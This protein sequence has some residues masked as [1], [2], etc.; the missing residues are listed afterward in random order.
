MSTSKTKKAPVVGNTA[1]P[2]AAKPAGVKQWPKSTNGMSASDYL[3]QAIIYLANHEKKSPLLT[4]SICWL[5]QANCYERNTDL[6]A[7]TDGLGVY[8]NTDWF[9]QMNVEERAFVFTHE[10]MHAIYRHV[11]QVKMLI[12]PDAKSHTWRKSNIAMDVLI[13]KVVGD[14]FVGVTSTKGS[15]GSAPF[16][17]REA[18]VGGV[19]IDTMVQTS[20]GKK[21]PLVDEAS[22]FDPDEHDWYWIFQ[23]LY[24]EAG[25]GDGE[26]GFGDGDDIHPGDG[27]EAGD[28]AAEIAAGRALSQAAARLA[29]AGNQ[30]G[31][32]GGWLDRLLQRV[33]T[34][35]HDWKNELQLA[36]TSCI[37]Q[38][39]S[40]RRINKTY[41]A[42]GACVGTISSP[43]CGPIFVCIDT[44]GSISEEMLVQPI[45]E[46]EAILKQMQPERIYQIWCDA[47][48]ANVQVL[49]PDQ[50]LDPKPAGGGG[51]DFKPAFDWIEKH[52]AETGEEP[53]ACL[54]FTDGYGGHTPHI[55][56][57]PVVWVV[58]P[59]GAANET[60]PF[61]KVI[62]LPQPS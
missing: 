29:A 30:C 35:V 38:N 37:P 53:A 46:T 43:G 36:V 41:A 10:S 1:T 16:K 9:A 5:L 50:P 18:N 14:A 45:N 51:T 8:I 23:R 39:Y 48:V 55:P 6:T 25:D 28:N 27:G 26:G 60:F 21:V 54:F 17:P 49:E 58:C 7:S 57:Y 52:R 2:P 42:L 56:D 33:A 31:N 15:N 62:R 20:T 44:S 61:G 47:E 19:F 22:K 32:G 12:G 34:P 24:E 40:F 4:I 59:G 13:N 3:S 11:Q